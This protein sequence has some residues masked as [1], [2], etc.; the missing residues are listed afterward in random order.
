MKG[1]RGGGFSRAAAR[2]AYALDALAARLKPLPSS[3][4]L[5]A[6]GTFSSAWAL[7]PQPEVEASAGRAAAAIRQARMSMSPGW[8]PT[9]AVG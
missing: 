8:A 3:P 1:G 5:K 9:S 2:A 7:G 6:Q 4:G